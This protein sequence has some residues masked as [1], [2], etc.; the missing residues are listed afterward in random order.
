MAEWLKALVSKTNKGNTF[1]GSNPSFS[2]FFFMYFDFCLLYV[3]VFFIGEMAEWL[4][5]PV[6]KTDEGNTSGGS[7]PS[8]SVYSKSSYFFY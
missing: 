6:L 1:E 5:A 3:I 4:K 8:F 2:V 7:N